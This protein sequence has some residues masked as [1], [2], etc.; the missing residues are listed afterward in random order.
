VLQGIA[1]IDGAHVKRPFKILIHAL[2]SQIIRR[3]SQPACASMRARRM[4]T[5]PDSAGNSDGRSVTVS[6]SLHMHRVCFFGES[7][8]WVQDVN[9]AGSRGFSVLPFKG[10]SRHCLGTRR[11][12]HFSHIPPAA[13]ECDIVMMINKAIDQFFMGEINAP[14]LWRWRG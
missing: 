3:P 11:I 2:C 8:C 14:R 7:R 6:N 1:W 10:K 9:R 13:D 5:L 12:F 4:K